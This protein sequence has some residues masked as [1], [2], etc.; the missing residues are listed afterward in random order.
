MGKKK[1][2]MS[3]INDKDTASHQFCIANTPHND[4]QCH[5]KVE[6]D[7]CSC[8]SVI[9]QTPKASFLKQESQVGNGGRLLWCQNLHDI[10]TCYNLYQTP[11]TSEVLSQVVFSG[12]FEGL[13]CQVFTQKKPG[14]LYGNMASIWFGPYSF[15]KGQFSYKFLYCSKL[16]Q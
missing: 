6:K 4:T 15:L 9:V 13:L 12:D 16:H 14:G 5:V 7:L 2:K 3:R 10:S 1:P 8:Q 11:Q